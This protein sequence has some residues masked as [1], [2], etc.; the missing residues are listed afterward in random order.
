MKAE[1]IL[2]TNDS[3]LRYLKKIKEKYSL[4]Q[5]RQVFEN[6][7]KIDVVVIGDTIIDEY[8]FTIPKG[9]AAKDPIM[10]LD[11]K[12][13]EKYAGGILA[14]TNHIAGFVNSVHLITV[15]GEQMR[16]EGLIR[17]SLKSNVKPIFFTKKDSPTVNKTRYVDDVRKGKLFKVEYM[18]DLPLEKDMEDKIIAHMKDVLPR[19]D[20]VVVG[21]FGHGFISNRMAREIEENSRFLAANVQTN[22]ANIGYNYITRYKKVDYLTTN[23]SEVRLAMSDKFGS[24]KEVIKKIQERTSFKNFILTMGGEGALYVKDKKVFEGP[25]LTRKTKDVVGAGDALFAVSSLLEKEGLE[26]DL[27]VFLSNCVGA[28]AVNIMGNK[29]SVRKDDLMEFIEGVYDAVE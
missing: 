20:M 2:E 9:R 5:I 10:S 28:I 6:L 17:K 1:D 3:I 21:D 16:E 23:E 4:D 12:R 14:V 15:L 11:F 27:I 25:G 7:K 19:Y 8:R 13:S 24:L 18:N 22:S 26:G 29:E